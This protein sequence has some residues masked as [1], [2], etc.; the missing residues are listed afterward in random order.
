MKKITLENYRK[1]KYY[2]RVVR[3][4]QTI[5]AKGGGIVAPVDVFVHMELLTKPDL[6]DW[7][8]GRIPYLERVIHCSLEKASR[9]LRILRMHLHDLNMRPSRTVYR[10]WG[11][12]VKIPLRFSKSGN[13]HL[14]GTYSLHFVAARM[15]TKKEKT[16]APSVSNG[17]IRF[18]D[19]L[20]DQQD[21]DDDIRF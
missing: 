19:P 12:G 4:V 20:Q 14:E 1:D 16:E 17:P 15:K 10:K 8:F 21:L 18:P 13:P 7:R 2:P 11:K 3:A 5:L 9:I 6:E